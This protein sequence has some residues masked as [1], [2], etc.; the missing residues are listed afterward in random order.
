MWDRKSLSLFDQILFLPPTFENEQ[1]LDFEGS[2]AIEFCSGNGEWVVQKAAE[3]SSRF[4]VAVERRLDRAKKIW[5][6]AKRLDVSNLLVVAGTAENFIRLIKKGSVA[7]VY[8][9][10]P[11]PW[12]KR[13]HAKH[14]LINP[15]FIKALKSRLKEGALVSLITDDKPTLDSALLGLESELKPRLPEPRYALDPPGYGGSFFKELWEKRS[16]IIYLTEYEND[17]S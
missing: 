9:N 1:P 16:R 15:Q 10:F 17:R 12:P 3:D 11:D 6:R 14:R 2:L 8:I 4:W 13:R 5:R 7:E